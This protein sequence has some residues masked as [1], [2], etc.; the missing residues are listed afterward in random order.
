[1]FSIYSNFIFFFSS[2]IYRLNLDRGQFLNPFISNA[3]EEINKLA[4]N[5]IHNMLLV[6]T[7]EGKIEAWDPRTRVSIGVMDCA[8]NSI[9]N[10]TNIV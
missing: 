1:M 5:P 2:E 6:G 4:V 7:K 9:D 3:G 10:N 8:L